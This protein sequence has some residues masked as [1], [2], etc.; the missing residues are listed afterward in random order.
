MKM[1]R[2]R[3]WL[4][5]MAKAEDEVG[6]VYI[7]PSS[8]WAVPAWTEVEDG[9]EWWWG[10]W[11]IRWWDATGYYLEVS[12]GCQY[13]PYATLEEAQKKAIEVRG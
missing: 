6:G 1:S 11:K 3:E 10:D 4:L 13:G 12:S 2:D 9:F 5:R 7:P 8:E